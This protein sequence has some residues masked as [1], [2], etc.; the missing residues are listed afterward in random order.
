V[1]ELAGPLEL[2]AEL[3]S[4][5]AASGDVEATLQRAVE[6]ITEHVGAEG[7]ALFLVEEG[8]A[9]GELVCH[10]STGPVKITGLRL[11][12]GR[13]I[14]GRCCETES[15][16]H[17]RDVREDPHWNPAIDAE[18]GFTTRSILCAPLVV[19]D[20]RLGA[21]ELVNK[22]SGDGLFGPDDASLLEALAASAALSLHNARIAERLV[23][24]ETLE[25]E[26][27]MA[28]EIQR[29]MLPAA[30]P[31]PFPLIGVNVPAR[32][33]SGDFYDWLERPDGRIVF[34]VGDVSGKG[35]DAAILMAKTASLFRCIA[36]DAADPGPLL[37][38]LNAEILETAT[39]GMFVTM[40]A[41]LLDPE[42]GTVRLAG[43]GHPPTLL[44]EA[45]GA[46]HE[47]PS[48]A[49]PLGIAPFADPPPEVELSLRGGSL[50]LFTDGV[51]E[52]RGPGEVMLGLEGLRRAI[53]ERSALSARARVESLVGDLRRGRPRDDLTLLV[54]DGDP[55]AARHGV[56]PLLSLRFPARPERLGAMREA[57]EAACREAGCGESCTRDVVLAVDEACQNV[58]RHAYAG[59]PDGEIELEITR[60]GDRLVVLVRDFAP[61][62]DPASVHPRDLADVRPGGL[63]THFIHELMDEEELR[64]V[65]P[66]PG[67]LLRMVKRIRGP[68]P[69]GPGDA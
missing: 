3:S 30:R 9:G 12:S 47:I 43:A 16:Q 46:W 7:G 31:A 35:I 49:A 60:D 56:V 40:A 4:E 20:R 42:R 33:V 67:N 29:S 8:A 34:C 66:G 27:R 32:G 53:D 55:A 18:T 26:V 69:E 50:Y 54:V 51:I 25:R 45:D 23:A 2:I 6:R 1:S 68:R 41:G 11:P 48:G 15:L 64:P 28:A 19:Q 44:R 38:R 10:A 21:I 22:L 5:F 13:G 62:S 52:S 59:D 39:R 61:P 14:V 57:V 17:V 36:R 63:G 58:I 24:R 37:A 65:E